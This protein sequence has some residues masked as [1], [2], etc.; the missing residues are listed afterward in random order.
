VCATNVEDETLL[1]DM[2]MEVV[3]V[4]YEYGKC[5]DENFSDLEEKYRN[6]MPPAP[7]AVVMEES[8]TDDAS[9]HSG[10]FVSSASTL[11]KILRQKGNLII[12]C[13]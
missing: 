11:S 5:Q 10:S 7:A 9:M 13:C 6:M 2:A 1:K 8:H 12:F 3:Q 4:L